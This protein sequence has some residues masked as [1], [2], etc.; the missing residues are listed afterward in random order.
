SS[1]P[2][3]SS[4][5]PSSLPPPPYLVRWYDLDFN[6]HLNNTIYVKW[7]LEACPQDVLEHGQLKRA[8]FLFRAEAQ[9]GDQVDAQVVALA[10]TG[11]LNKLVRQGDGKEL[12]LGQFYWG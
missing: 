10:D 6:K 8:D 4:P 9:L 1:I 11:F 2:L 12:A 5:P 3:A 7:L